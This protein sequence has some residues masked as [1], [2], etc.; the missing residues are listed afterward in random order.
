MHG[1]VA[2]CDITKP[3]LIGEHCTKNNNLH[4]QVARTVIMR[5]KQLEKEKQDRGGDDED[6][7]FTPLVMGEGG[8]SQKKG[9]AC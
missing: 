3:S 6:E 5:K 9:C 2:L 1:A 7:S 8:S 4:T